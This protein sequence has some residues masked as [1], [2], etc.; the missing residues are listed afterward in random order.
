MFW[1]L[2]QVTY[3]SDELLVACGGNGLSDA[4]SIW[5]SCSFLETPAPCTG[6][7]VIYQVMMTLCQEGDEVI[8]P[9]PY[10]T[11]YPAS[12]PKKFGWLGCPNRSL[13]AST[14]IRYSVLWE[15]MRCPAEMT[16]GHGQVVWRHPSDHGDTSITRLCHRC[17]QAG[18]YHYT[19]DAYADRVSAHLDSLVLFQCQCLHNSLWNVGSFCFQH[20]RL[21][22]MVWHRQLCGFLFW[23]VQS[24][25]SNRRRRFGHIVS[26]KYGTSAPCA[27]RK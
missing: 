16:S 4:P 14:S 25:K 19:E 15:G 23:G 13:Q 1:C 12:W 26:H 22:P 11:S 18:C 24:I 27:L 2:V 6:K 21:V 3:S 9:A 8:V 20:Q 5:E 10:W 7:Q 17:G